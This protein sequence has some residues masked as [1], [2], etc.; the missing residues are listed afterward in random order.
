MSKIANFHNDWLQCHQY[1]ITSRYVLEGSCFLNLVFCYWMLVTMESRVQLK[2]DGTRWRTGKWR[3]NWRMEWVASTL[4]LPRNAVYPA[5]LPLMSTPRLNW[6]PGRFKW[7]RTFA[8]RPNLVSARVPSHFKHS[9]LWVALPL[10]WKRYGLG[11]QRI[12]LGIQVATNIF[13]TRRAY[14]LTFGFNHPITQRPLC[15]VFAIT[16]RPGQGNNP[17]RA[18][19]KVSCTPTATSPNHIYEAC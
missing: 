10:Q 5:L 14:R 17:H 18:E 3:G 16:K 19:A 13:F 11:H 15:A 2:P 1:C 7:T 6:R 9:L 8:E 12:G 4:T